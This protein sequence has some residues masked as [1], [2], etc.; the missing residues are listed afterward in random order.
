MPIQWPRRRRDLA[1]IQRGVISPRQALTCG[2]TA[3]TIDGLVRSGRWPPHRLG[4]YAVYRRGAG[5]AG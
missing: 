5:L 2:L 3:D 1:E 4:V